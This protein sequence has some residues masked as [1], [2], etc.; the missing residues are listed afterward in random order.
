MEGSM[1]ETERLALREVEAD[2]APAFRDYMTDAAYWRNLPIDPPT[3][4]SL[5]AFLDQCVRDQAREPRTAYFLAA[6][7]TSTGRLVGEGILHVRGRPWPQG[8]IGWGVDTA[9]TGAGLATEIGAAM[10]RLAFDQLGLHRVTA[11]CRVSHA[12]SRRIMTKLGMREEGVLREDVFAR[13]EW[14]S[15]LQCSILSQEWR[16]PQ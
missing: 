11:R 9:R 10:L 2:D 16:G 15:S 14:W 6:I 8:E 4:S 12:A 7:E 3:L 1:L 5:R 13:G